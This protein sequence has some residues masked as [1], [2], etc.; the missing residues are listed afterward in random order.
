MRLIAILLRAALPVLL[1]FCLL[2]WLAGT[3]AAFALDTDRM[4]RGFETYADEALTGLDEDG[5]A[6]AAKGITD[7]LSGKTDSAQLELERFG[8]KSAAFSEKEWRHLED[9]RK[10]I[11]LAQLLRT[12]ALV[13]ITAAIALF[14]ALRRF[15]PGLLAQVRPQ[16]AVTHTLYA[17][18]ALAV[19]LALWAAADFYSLFVVFHKLLFRNDL[20][21]LDPR[22]DL[23]L[24]LMPLEFFVAYGRELLKQSCPVLLCLPLAAYALGKAGKDKNELS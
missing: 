11:S 18:C 19:L 24:E 14:F 21:L 22:R 16:K 5:Y 10:L 15:W 12:L 4:A 1:V 6:K 8:E 2:A 7:Y 23:L 9:I 17:V 3:L 13:L 20:W